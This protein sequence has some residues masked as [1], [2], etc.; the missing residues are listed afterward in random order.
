M[1]WGV[2]I[3][4]QDCILYTD[5]IMLQLYGSGIFLLLNI[6]HYGDLDCQLTPNMYC[7]NSICTWST[8]KVHVIIM[9]YLSISL[10]SELRM[11]RPAQ[12]LTGCIMNELYNKNK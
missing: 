1:G 5:R 3:Y 12:V 10:L 4:G 9:S 6:C 2:L 11:T 8:A 7:H